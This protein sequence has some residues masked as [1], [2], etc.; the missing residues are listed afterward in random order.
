MNRENGSLRRMSTT[1]CAFFVLV[2]LSFQTS[3]FAQAPK[4]IAIYASKRVPVSFDQL[5]EFAGKAELTV[6]RGIEKEWEQVEIKWPDVTI[7]F[8][9]SSI[10]TDESLV[11]HLGGFQGY[12]YNRLANGKMDSQVFGLIRQIDKTNHLYTIQADPDIS[13]DAIKQFATKLAAS[14]R[15]L[16]FVNVEVFDANMKVLLGPDKSHDKDAKLPGFE[17]AEKRKAKTTKLLA[18]KKLK[19]LDTLPVVLADEQVRLR[20]PKEVARRAV[21]LFALAAHS[22]REGFEW[23]KFLTKHNLLDSLSP[24]EKAFLAN[25]KLT[26]QDYSSMTWRYE[27]LW[28]LLWALGHV[29]EPGFPDKQSDAA[30][31]MKIVMENPGDLIEKAKLRPASAILDQADLLY[32]CMWIC[33]DAQQNQKKLE[34]LSMSVVFERLYALNWLIHHGNA[35]WDNVQTDS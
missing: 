28:S 32:R 6:L 8:G 22:E 1:A 10:A 21:C 2:F 35:N 27:A 16:I 7:K 34:G 18:E 13:S 24:K 3:V 29:D 26:D 19:V 25:D 11:Q 4:N 33:R 31:A 17:S 15:A 20:E 9:Q 23:A 14:E 12:V 5:K 30:K